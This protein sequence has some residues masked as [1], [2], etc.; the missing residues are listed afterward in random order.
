MPFTKLGL[1]PAVLEGVRAAGYITPTPI[2]LRGIPLVLSGRDV[3]G[4][5]Q[6]GTGKTAAF[7]LP[8][9]HRLA[10]NKKP[11]PKRGC[12]CL[13]HLDPVG[14]SHGHGNAAEVL[15]VTRHATAF[16]EKATAGS[17]H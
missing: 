15:C 8:I 7:A 4:S 13:V 16:L 14:A 9:L 12:R 1:S 2:Q 6:T 5:A 11:A 10:A 3:I 17:L